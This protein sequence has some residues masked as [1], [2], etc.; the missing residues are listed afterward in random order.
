MT[1]ILTDDGRLLSGYLTSENSETVGLRDLASGDVQQISVETIEDRADKGTAMP[2]GFT[3]SLTR[4]ELRD[5]IAY[6]A[7]L[8]AGGGKP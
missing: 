1:T 5:L 8:K 7:G 2:S 3:H 4:Q 6:L